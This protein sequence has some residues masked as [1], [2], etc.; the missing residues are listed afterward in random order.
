M[1]LLAAAAGALIIGIPL[2]GALYYEKQDKGQ[3][4][5]QLAY[6]QKLQDQYHYASVYV[7]TEDVVAG[8]ELTT[9]MLQ[10]RR[11]QSTEDLSGLSAFTIDDLL[12]KRLK[13]SL[14]KGSTIYTDMVYEG[15]VI[16]DDERRVEITETYLPETLRE[17]EFVDIRIAF[18]DGEDYIIMSHKRIYQLLRDEEQQVKAVVL[19]MQEEELLR[20]QSACVDMKTYQDTKLY[21]LQYTGEYQT[22]AEEFYPVNAAVFR[23]LSWDPNIISLF[24]VESETERRSVLEGHLQKYLLDKPEEVPDDPIVVDEDLMDS[25]LKEPLE[26]YTGLPEDETLTQN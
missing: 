5:E 3:V 21:A 1:M 20:Y 25:Q 6:Y 7:L 24:V 9:S 17:N 2:T 18:P 16:A 11:I 13:V 23:L 10:E 22:S 4:R 8:D 14:A 15:A 26:L 19:R 12:G